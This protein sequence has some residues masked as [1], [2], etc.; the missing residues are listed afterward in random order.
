MAHMTGSGANKRDHLR[1]IVAVGTRRYRS[2]TITAGFD[3]QRGFAARFISLGTVR[4]CSAPRNRQDRCAVHHGQERVANVGPAQLGQ[5]HFVQIVPH[6]RQVSKP[7]ESPAGHSRAAAYLLR[8]VFPCN[9]GLEHEQDP[10]QRLSIVDGF[11]SRVP[12][13]PAFR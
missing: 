6:L 4:S 1:Y 10:G 7:K 8:K 13:T 11:C 5:Q 9:P 3:D 2:Q 12:G